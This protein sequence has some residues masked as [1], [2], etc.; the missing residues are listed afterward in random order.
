[1]ISRDQMVGPVAVAV[2]DVAV[3]LCDYF[4]HA[5]ERCRWANGRRSAG[6]RRAR[7]GRLAVGEALTTFSRPDIGSLST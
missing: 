3:T 7:F 6:A 5:G 1:M 4:G 2:A